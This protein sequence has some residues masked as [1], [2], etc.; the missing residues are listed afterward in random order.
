[1]STVT[2]MEIPEE[3]CDNLLRRET[4]SVQDAQLTAKEIK[5]QAANIFNK[6]VENIQ[7]LYL[8]KMLED[9]DTLESVGVSADATLLVYPKYHA[10]K[11]MDAGDP[12]EN[13]DKITMAFGALDRQSLLRALCSDQLL[14]KLTTAM[15]YLSNGILALIQKPQL[16]KSLISDKDA[17]NTLSRQ[18]PHL[19]D[20]LT[21]CLSLADTSQRG[22][23]R[24]GNI[25]SV[26]ALSDDEE[27]DA[28]DGQEAGPSAGGSNRQGAITNE[29]L[30][31]ALQAAYSQQ[32]Q[33]ASQTFAAQLET[34]REMGLTDE[35]SCIQALVKTGG[36]VHAAVALLFQD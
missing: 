27:D 2:L 34:M 30:Q 28:Q 33:V 7:L 35:V 29:M 10:T 13:K 3:S 14:T 11:P 32:S 18:Y 24:T 12:T 4:I 22:A 21:S 19:G 20:A 6:N 36:D 15:P 17:L 26:D 16:L 1:M 5:R 23:L 8:G 9:E 25:Y 31:A